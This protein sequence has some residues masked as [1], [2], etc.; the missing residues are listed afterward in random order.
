M[1]HNDEIE[2]FRK[3]KLPMYMGIINNSLVD[4]SLYDAKCKKQK[5]LTKFKNMDKEYEIKQ[6][7]LF[8]S[9]ELEKK[10]VLKAIKEVTA[11]IEELERK[12]KKEKGW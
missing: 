7:R 2:K 6:Q 3:E 8:A 5:L 11:L 1:I 4:E 12:S 10:S 9:F